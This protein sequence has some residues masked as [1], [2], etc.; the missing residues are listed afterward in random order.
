MTDRHVG[1]CIYC[2]S[3]GPFSDE[4]VVSAGLGGDDDHWLLKDCV[5]RVCNTEIFSKQEAKFLRASPIGIARLFLQDRTRDR[6]NRAS[7]PSIQPNLTVYGDEATGTL[8]AALMA[9]KGKTAILPQIVAL[10]RGDA[11]DI[12][13]TGSDIQSVREFLE[14]FDGVLTD[15]LVLIEKRRDGFEFVF[16]LTPLSW[17]VDAYRAG[18][19]RVASTPEKDGIWIDALTRPATAGVNYLLPLAVFQLPKGQIVC[20]AGS[21]AMACVLLSFLRQNP[22]I[23]Q[24]GGVGATIALD[25]RP[26]VHLRFAVDLAGYDRVL[27]KI[28]IN[29]CA[30]ILGLDLVRDPAF[31]RAVEYARSGIGAVYKAPAV[32]DQLLGPPLPDC[33]SMALCPAPGA[34]GENA[35]VFLAQFYGGPW[36]RFR[37][38]E[39]AQPIDGLSLP[40]I[41]HVNYQNH[42][43]ERLTLEEHVTRAAAVYGDWTV[44]G[45]PSQKTEVVPENRTG[46]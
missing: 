4:H 30:F 13:V 18:A 41:V 7:A 32:S 21:P 28:G 33:H 27:T 23:R 40:I 3:L 24:P 43:I 29:L 38:A 46:V 39:F 45:S 1:G 14:R 16:D 34:T 36:E 10:P 25:E 20:R 17:V 6:G 15:E 37:L 5:C 2:G 12:A 19:P 42:R 8:L 44:S 9:E 22:Q 11:V 26:G 35:I 31:D